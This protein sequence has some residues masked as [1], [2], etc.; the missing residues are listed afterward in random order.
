M[1]LLN[2]NSFGTILKASKVN[3]L[4]LFDPE[5]QVLGYFEVTVNIYKST[6]V[7][8]YSCLI[9]KVAN[10]VRYELNTA[11]PFTKIK[12]LPLVNYILLHENKQVTVSIVPCISVP[13]IIRLWVASFM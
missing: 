1:L 8:S 13:G 5:K 12:C 7:T 2:T 9:F 10:A 11:T 3:F 4:E 6:L